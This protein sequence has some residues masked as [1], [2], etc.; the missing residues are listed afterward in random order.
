[1]KL[2][3]SL[4]ED[5]KTIFKYLKICNFFFYTF[6][7]WSSS[8][9]SSFL[10]LYLSTFPF[11]VQ[12]VVP[13]PESDAKP[14]QAVV[15]KQAVSNLCLQALWCQS[16][17]TPSKVWQKQGKKKFNKGK[18]QCLLKFFLSSSTVVSVFMCQPPTLLHRQHMM[19]LDWVHWQLLLAAHTC[20]CKRIGRW[21]DLNLSYFKT[22]FKR[23]SP[24]KTILHFL[25]S[26]SAL[27]TLM[28]IHFAGQSQSLLNQN[29]LR[30]TWKL[31]IILKMAEFG[32]NFN[33]YSQLLHWVHSWNNLLNVN[34]A[35]HCNTVSKQLIF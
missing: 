13:Q 21:Q 28:P 35:I 22:C 17:W 15:W 5:S 20:G 19:W 33:L 9:L 30:S 29:Q 34:L 4:S 6:T 10:S 11:P 7:F 16:Y 1:M 26:F 12:W 23:Q 32:E 18:H 3:A 27:E 2:A 24:F 8:F 31:P 25:F 14:D